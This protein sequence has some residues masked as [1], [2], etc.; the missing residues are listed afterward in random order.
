MRKTTQRAIGAMFGLL[1]MVSAVAYAA[2]R[3]KF[4]LKK[5]HYYR[6]IVQTKG[7][8]PRLYDDWE[9]GIPAVLMS[10]VPN[11]FEVE[12]VSED[13]DVTDWEYRFKAMRDRTQPL[14]GA[15]GD[16]YIGDVHA[17]TE[18]VSV[19]PITPDTLP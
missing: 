1:A 18:V 12:L 4:V 17:K 14:K 9:Q 2:V 3:E 11:E 10:D 15:Q 5:G 6:V 7:L 16:T 13:G 19:A 8:P